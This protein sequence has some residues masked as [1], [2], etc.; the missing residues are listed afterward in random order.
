MPLNISLTSASK[1]GRQDSNLR[2]MSHQMALTTDFTPH[3]LDFGTSWGLSGAKESVEFLWS[4]V[5]GRW[6]RIADQAQ[7]PAAAAPRGPDSDP[8]VPDDP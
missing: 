7:C 6:A 5:A 3:S 8:L 1:S 2:Y 4:S